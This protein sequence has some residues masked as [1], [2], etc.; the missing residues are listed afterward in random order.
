MIVDV[1]AQNGD[2]AEALTL[3]GQ[4][5]ANYETIHRLDVQNA[6]NALSDHRRGGGR[7][8]AF[9]PFYTKIPLSSEGGS[10]ILARMRGGNHIINLE[11]MTQPAGDNFRALRWFYTK[12]ECEQALDDGFFAHPNIGSIFFLR[13]GN[14]FESFTNQICADV[15]EGK[16]VSV[17]IVGSMFGG[18]GAAGIPSILRILED[19]CR[20]A[21]FAEDQRRRL[22]MNAVLVTPYFKVRAP[23]GSNIHI[24]SDTFFGNTKSALEFYGMRY[25]NRFERLYLVGQNDLEYVSGS[26]EDGG[27]AQRNKPHIVELIAAL[28]VKDSW[29]VPENGSGNGI[30]ELILQNNG[31]DALFGW[32]SLDEELFY[33][34]HMVRTQFLLKAYIVPAV[35]EGGSSSAW[36]ATFG[37]LNEQSALEPMAQYMDSFL[38]WIYEIQHRYSE[39]SVSQKVMDGRI[40]LCGLP[41]AGLLSSDVR[42]RENAKDNFKD[43]ID[44]GHDFTQAQ[45]VNYR[46]NQPERIIND[47]G[48][49]GLFDRDAKRLASLKSTGLFIQLFHDANRRA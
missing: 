23:K 13:M 20:T 17:S 46:R 10:N 30:R 9:R 8:E 3:Y 44:K 16:E 12:R 29:S 35:A 21:G 32:D 42:D 48:L 19:A 41:L 15:R 5:Q 40:T 18:T 28:G 24:N 37:M 4:Y 39:T 25:R 6:L 34:A 14:L 11:T 31:N 33:M 7:W 2:I 27:I 26:Y 1:D 43:L 38:N 47:L 36:F 22:H 45:S 49:F